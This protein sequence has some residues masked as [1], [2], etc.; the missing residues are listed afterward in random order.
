MTWVAGDPEVPTQVLGGLRSYLAQGLSTWGRRMY[1]QSRCLCRY[2]YMR[3]MFVDGMCNIVVFLLLEVF[4]IN[5][6]PEIYQLLHDYMLMWAWP[7]RIYA[8]KLRRIFSPNKK[9]K[10]KKAAHIK[11][12]A[13]DL[14]TLIPAIAVFVQKVLLKLELANSARHAFISLASI[15]NL[16][17]PASIGAM[18]PA[19]LHSAVERFLHLFVAGFGAEWMTPKFHWMLHFGDHYRGMACC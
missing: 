18:D 2:D 17:Q 13:S 7:I 15:V 14:L 10:H 1:Q 9:D 12:Q 16:F 3:G 6:V 8:H 11:C 19:K 5:C 4:L